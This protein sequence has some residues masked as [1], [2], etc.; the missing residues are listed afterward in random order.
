MATG[1]RTGEVPAAVTLSI[2]T[3]GAPRMPFLTL[4]W[5]LIRPFWPYI[6]A[7]LA[8]VGA[9]AYMH[10]CGYTAG[11]DETEAKYAEAA[12]KAQARAAALETQLATANRALATRADGVATGNE[13]IAVNEKAR[14]DAV[15]A[16]LRRWLRNNAASD[17]VPGADASARCADAAAEGAR[18][19]VANAA[20][21]RTNAAQVD[22][23]QIYAGQAMK[24]CGNQIP[25]TTAKQLTAAEARFAAREKA[26]QDAAK[27]ISQ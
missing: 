11:V 22:A 1:T 23:L 26:V 19:A 24:L 27:A 17:G 4:V 18:V 9:A 7:A 25:L 15:I 21:A 12:R 8:V 14:T 6:V 5:G 2:V 13:R 3:P 10:H 16:D 20:A